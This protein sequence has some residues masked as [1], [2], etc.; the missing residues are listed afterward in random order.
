VEFIRHLENQ[1]VTEIPSTVTFECE[2]SKA[3]VKVSWQKG[4]IVIMPS[5]KY[6]VIMDKTVHRYYDNLN[7]K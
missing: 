2:L 4:D 3:N 1:K 7:N 6:E 5:A